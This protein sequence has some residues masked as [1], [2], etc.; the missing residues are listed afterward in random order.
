MSA[1]TP[2]SKVG[3]RL[4]KQSTSAGMISSE[5]QHKPPSQGCGAEPEPEPP[6]PTHFGRSRSRSRSHRNGLLGAG[7]GAGAG[8]VKNGAAPAPKRDAIVTRIKQQQRNK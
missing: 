1:Q 3:A 2:T 7:A 8:A 5:H 4:A 6:E